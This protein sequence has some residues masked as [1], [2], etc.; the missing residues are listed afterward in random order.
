MGLGHTKRG[1]FFCYDPERTGDTS[2]KKSTKTRHQTPDQRRESTPPRTRGP[3][4]TKRQKRDSDNSQAKS[5][6]T[7]SPHIKHAGHFQKRKK[8]GQDKR[9]SKTRQ[10]DTLDTASQARNRGQSSFKTNGPRQTSTFDIP[11]RAKKRAIR[12]KG[13]QS[14]FP[15]KSN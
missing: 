3:R 8:K 1:A 14:C 7:P 13:R 12:P 4:L 11:R 9:Q 15:S 6:S 2:K 5:K 10:P